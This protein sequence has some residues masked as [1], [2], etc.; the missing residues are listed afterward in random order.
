MVYDLIAIFLLLG[1]ILGIVVIVGRKL[2]RL[3]TLNVETIPAERELRLK[4]R[5]LATRLRRRLR[6]LGEGIAAWARPFFGRLTQRMKRLPHWIKE[7]E[8]AYR[9][10]AAPAATPPAS[11]ELSAL[12][13]AAEQLQARGDHAAAEDQLMQVVARD[14][15]H[16]GAYEQ[17]GTLYLASRDYAKAREVYSY[18]LKLLRRHPPAGNNVKSRAA[19]YQLN[20]ATAYLELGRKAQ[21]LQAARKA[22]TLEPN[23]PRILDFL[24]KISILVKDKALAETTWQALHQADPD[25]AKLDELRA[26]INELP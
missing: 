26:Q 18:L 13:E 25:N 21:A 12:L 14:P 20:V 4:Q 23:N 17:L 24:L 7:L 16:V 11:A 3:K 5:I 19:A 15:R 6:A 1:C 8:A 10:P 22:A 9:R 2:P